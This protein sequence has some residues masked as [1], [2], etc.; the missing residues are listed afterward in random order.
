MY[1]YITVIL[2][3]GLILETSHDC[4]QLGGL[5]AMLHGTCVIDIHAPS[6]AEKNESV[7]S[8]NNDLSYLQPTGKPEMTQAGMLIVYTP[9][10]TAQ[11]RKII[12]QLS[13]ASCIDPTSQM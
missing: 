10:Q 1:R 4:P 12:A 13:Q 9:T 7:R 2:A 11:V 5:A 8:Y 3:K 6:G